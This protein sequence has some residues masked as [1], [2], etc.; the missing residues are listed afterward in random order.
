MTG[1]AIRENPAAYPVESFGYRM[2][3]FPYNG[4]M[5]QHDFPLIEI[6]PHPSLTAAQLHERARA[7]GCTMIAPPGFTV[8]ADNRILGIFPPDGDAPIQ[9]SIRPRCRN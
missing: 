9:I 2:T 5:L 3:D 4:Y 7:A 8:Y 6:V 1:I